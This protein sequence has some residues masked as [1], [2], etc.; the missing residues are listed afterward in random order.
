MSDGAAERTQVTQ[1]T[2]PDV[3][4]RDGGLPEDT[5]INQEQE[6]CFDTVVA[7]KRHAQELNK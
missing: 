3:K 7:M 1:A 2:S 4:P 6:L 5:H